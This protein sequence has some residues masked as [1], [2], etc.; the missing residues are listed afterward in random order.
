MTL[1]WIAVAVLGGLGLWL[2][3]ALAG[4]VR[5]LVVLRARVDALE[6]GAGA[7]DH[8]ASGLPPGAPAP[9]WEAIDADGSP[10]SSR[11]FTGRRHLLLFA[12]AD[13]AACDDIVPFVV[14]ASAEGSLPP[15]AV[16]AGEPLD[17]APAT[18]RPSAGR[19]TVVVG[20][21]RGRDV[22]A[23]YHVDITPTVF[24]VDEGGFVAARGAPTSPDET[25]DLVA[26]ADGIRIVAGAG[27]G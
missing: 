17:H 27:D 18:W 22:S 19:G 10:V 21:E 2:G 7:P 16:I 23:R 4:A 13:C 25:R 1:L 8:L 20:A 15:A 14:R 26:S 6:A 5:E 24:V 9:A 3:L 11:I 12:D